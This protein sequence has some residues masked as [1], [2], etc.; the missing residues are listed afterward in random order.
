MTLKLM[1]GWES[2]R[3]DSDARAQGWVAGPTKRFLAFPS[4]VTGLPGQSMALVGAN[5]SGAAGTPGVAG[6]VDPAY[7][8]T[9]ITVNQAW[10]AGGFTFGCGAKFNSGTATSY[11]AG[12]ANNNAQL[13]WDGSKYWA[14]QLA[15]A[16]YSVA[17]STDLVTWTVTA[18]QPGT[19][20]SGSTISYAGG[21]MIVVCFSSANVV[22]FAYTINNGASWSSGSVSPGLGNPYRTVV[23]AT[24]NAT[25]PHML[26]ASSY[27]SP[28]PGSNS[29]TYAVYVGTIGGT[30]TSVATA[31]TAGGASVTQRPKSIGGI[32]CVGGCGGSAT[33]ISMAL[34]NNASLNTTGAWTSINSPGYQLDI[35]YN[36][37]SNLWVCAH[38]GGIS[39][40][41][42]TGSAGTPTIPPSQP[43]FTARYSTVGIMALFTVGTKLVGVGLS[44]HIIT[45]SDGG[46]TWVEQG[47]HILPVG[48]SGTDWRTAIYD[49]TRYVL[50]SDAANGLIVTTPDLQTDYQVTYA[51]E[52]AETTSG[53]LSRLGV[54]A[55]VPPFGSTFT[56][57]ANGTSGQGVGLVAGA[58]SAG[59]RPVQAWQG[60]SSGASFQL[61]TTAPN[62][63]VT[64]LYHYYELKFTKDPATVNNFFVAVYVDGTVQSGISAA[65]V[66]LGTGTA[67]TTSLLALAFPRSGQWSMFDDLYFTLDDGTGMVGPLGAIN[68][69]ARRPTNDVQA[70]W[71]KNGGAASNSLSVNQHAL[72][73]GSANFNSSNAAGDKDIYSS[74]DSLPAGYTPRAVMVEGYF[75]RTSTTA[76]SVSIGLK[77]GSTESDSANVSLPNS[78]TTYVSQV[79][80]TD[81]NGGAAWTRTAVLNADIV[82]NHVT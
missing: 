49:G 19:M 26:I 41:P 74:S 35:E 5:S 17:Y 13:C 4:S 67:D 75:T 24:G 47:A 22:S 16:S 78:N 18:A 29:G 80:Q 42:N 45:S 23:A 43:T 77:S 10:A 37:T 30:L 60:Q 8:N 63:S 11:G 56:L 3:D 71:V 7:Y 27:Y 72:S 59:N 9:G 44:G 33:K 62:V 73:S 48:T 58:V 76:P 70:Q 2:C 61:F 21:G 68:I 82:V 38:N 20:D 57:A 79:Y 50:A 46:I 36:S 54:W 51:E 65:S 34:A 32:L 15:G 52:N 31:A 12:V 55:V 69:V 39:T 6:T 40:F 66:P 1:Q 25:Y 14:I 28:N 64:P 81:P 53:Y